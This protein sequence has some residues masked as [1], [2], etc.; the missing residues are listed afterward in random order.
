MKSGLVETMPLKIVP[1]VIAA[2]IMVHAPALAEDPEQFYKNDY[3]ARPD[4]RGS[5]PDI[6]KYDKKGTPASSSTE[7]N[8]PPTDATPTKKSESKRNILVIAYVNSVNSEH[9]AKVLQ[10]V[11]RL[12][13]ERQAFVYGVFHVGLYTAVTREIDADLT[14][15]N[16]Q[17]AQIDGPPEALQVTQSP[18]W[19]IKTKEG[20][21]IVE[22]EISLRSYF[23]EF[24]TF[25]HQGKGGDAKQF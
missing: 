6:W 9:F 16:I 17:V 21:H 1:A 12:H 14:S 7:H 19:L 10:E 23:D 24:G 13:D 18:T 4:V 2:L 22:G 11:L 20:V 8:R 25:N 5:S 15:R 3:A